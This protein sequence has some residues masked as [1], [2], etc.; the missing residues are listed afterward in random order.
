MSECKCNSCKK[1]REFRS[2]VTE[3]DFEKMAKFAEDMH[4]AWLNAET[5]YTDTQF[6]LNGSSIPSIGKL[7]KGIHKWEESFI[8]STEGECALPRYT[9]EDVECALPRYTK[10]D[11][12]DLWNSVFSNKGAEDLPRSE[13]PFENVLEIARERYTLSPTVLYFLFLVHK[14]DVIQYVNDE[15]IKLL[16]SWRLRIGK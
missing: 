16:V 14:D 9:K 4:E 7:I 1:S 15:E 12:D 10:E 11:V 3:R 2:I 8:R 5:E 13:D 6:T